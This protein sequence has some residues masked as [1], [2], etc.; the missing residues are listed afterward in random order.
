MTLPVAPS[1]KP[2]A[3]RVPFAEFEDL[4]DRMALMGLVS[5]G[6]AGQRAALPWPP[7]AGVPGAGDACLIGA[8]LPG[9]R[10]DQV[11]VEVSGGDLVISGEIT[12]R[13][14]GA[15]GAAPPAGRAGSSPARCFRPAP[16]QA[17]CQRRWPT[18]C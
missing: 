6:P 7:L 12:H 5:A 16:A 2:A 1:R 14:R 15:C 13:D 18:A 9:V 4:H 17:R 10:Q 11:S 3:R 8:G